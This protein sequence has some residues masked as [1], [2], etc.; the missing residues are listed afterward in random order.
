[1]FLLPVP[2]IGM[3][4]AGA[5][6]VGPGDIVSGAQAFWGLR[7]YSN[8]T[9]GA[10]AVKLRRNSDN[11]DQDFATQADGGLSAAAITSFKG[12]ATAL[13][14]RTLY[15]QTGNGNDATIVGPATFNISDVDLSLPTFSCSNGAGTEYN[16]SGPTIASQPFTVSQVFI[17][18]SGGGSF[19]VLFRSGAGCDIFAELA[20]TPTFRMADGGN[21]DATITSAQ[22]YAAQAIFNN[23]SSVAYINGSA[24]TGSVAGTHG[25]GGT[26]RLWWNDFTGRAAEMGIWDS[27]FDSTERSD[28]EA[29]QRAY[30]GF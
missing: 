22:W 7:A 24:T 18:D 26:L 16:A 4:A 19:P 11:T 25:V 30:W 13:T 2:L 20:S 5:P 3:G 17:D 21:L 28:V 27:A 14:V 29:N 10:N 1:M 6:Y 23:T 12:A 9:I 8:A 15:D